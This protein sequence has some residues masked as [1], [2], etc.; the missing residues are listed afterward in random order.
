MKKSS[1][2]IEGFFVKGDDVER[3]FIC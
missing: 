3:Y 1:I 2:E